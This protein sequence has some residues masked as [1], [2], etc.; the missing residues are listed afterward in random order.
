MYTIWVELRK[1][2]ELFEFFVEFAYYKQTD[3]VPFAKM[4]WG[5][6]ERWLSEFEW[7]WKH[8]F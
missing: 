1:K 5:V 2:N 8:G 4:R 7:V 3:N 6:T